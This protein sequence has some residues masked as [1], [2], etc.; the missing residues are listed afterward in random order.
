ML[1][2][3]VVSYSFLFC[4][5][6]SF[7]SWPT[8]SMEIANSSRQSVSPC[9]RLLTVFLRIDELFFYFLYDIREP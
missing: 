3:V 5:Y 7:T 2:I 6:K 4:K 1:S 8:I 9:F